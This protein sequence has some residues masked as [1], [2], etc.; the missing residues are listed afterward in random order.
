MKIAFPLL[1]TLALVTASPTR[2]EQRADISTGF[3]QDGDNV[4]V[5]IAVDGKCDDGWTL[6]HA[7]DKD[8]CC[9]PG[10]QCDDGGV[11][12]Q[13]ND[14]VD[15]QNNAWLCYWELLHCDAYHCHYRYRCYWI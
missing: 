9:P 7:N 13:A 1:A 14:D 2:L 6:F 11:R 15:V 8:L 12:A 4:N 3:D 5:P 10:K